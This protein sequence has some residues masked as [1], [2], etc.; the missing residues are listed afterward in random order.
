MSRSVKKHPVVKDGDSGVFGKKLA[1]KKVRRT[2]D[3][4][5]KG[6]G[7]RKIFESWDIHDYV[8]RWT[9]EEAIEMWIDEE[10]DRYFH[11]YEGYFH[12]RFN[13]N[14]DRYLG[15]WQRETLGK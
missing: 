12:R 11:N 2:E 4:P 14:F 3:V 1:N 10:K 5:M 7:Y 6:K 13:N 8:N 9:K 15:W